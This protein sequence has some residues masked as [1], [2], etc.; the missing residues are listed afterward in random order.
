MVVGHLEGHRL[1]GGVELPDE[2]ADVV[3]HDLGRAEGPHAPGEVRG[4]PGPEELL[5]H[6]Q[7]DGAVPGDQGGGVEQSDAAGAGVQVVT[8]PR[9]GK[10]R[11]SPARAR[12]WATPDSPASERTRAIS[13]WMTAPET[14]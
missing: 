7:R 2:R 9:V 8:S 5:S 11:C 4:V 10:E 13:T 12:V 14:P 3:E 1:G 6:V